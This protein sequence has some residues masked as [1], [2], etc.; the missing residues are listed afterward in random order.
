MSLIID[1]II[2]V[3]RLSVDADN[4]NKESY[5]PNLALQCVKCQL[6]PAGAEDTAIAQGVFGQ[7]YIGFT[8]NSGV[9]AG[10]HVTVSGTSKKYRVRGVQDW[11]LPDLIPHY[12]W[13]LINM[14][15]D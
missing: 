4:S 3:S 13:T 10:D 11:S 5:Q 7:T 15:E 8:T 14:E 1:T 12:E 6:Q 9:L 2:S